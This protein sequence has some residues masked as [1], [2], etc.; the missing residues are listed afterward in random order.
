MNSSN[1]AGEAPSVLE[2]INSIYVIYSE[3]GLHACS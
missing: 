3:A 2:A 1:Y